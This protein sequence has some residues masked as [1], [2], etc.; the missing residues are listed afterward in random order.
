M[1]HA[2]LGTATARGVHSAAKPLQTGGEE[3]PEPTWKRDM[4]V[5][6]N[7]FVDPEIPKEPPW[8]PQTPFGKGARP[9]R[10]PCPLT[11]DP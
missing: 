10:T 1:R 7:L 4:R 5:Y 2:Y 8:E 11:P 6:F 9:C 3:V